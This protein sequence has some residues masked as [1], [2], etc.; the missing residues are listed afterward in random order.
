MKPYR[1][2]QYAVRLGLGLFILGCQGRAS[3]WILQNSNTSHLG[4]GVGTRRYLGAPVELRSLR[5]ASCNSNLKA[6]NIF[7]SMHRITSPEHQ[8]KFRTVVYGQTPDG[9]KTE[10]GPRP[11]SRGCY[12]AVIHTT[13][14][15]VGGVRFAVDSIG[16]IREL[17]PGSDEASRKW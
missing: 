7:W 5:V 13:Y 2:R 4:F 3:I 15:Q 6:E 10:Y 17:R 1:I 8:E 11:L 14:G 12:D 9:F 16:N